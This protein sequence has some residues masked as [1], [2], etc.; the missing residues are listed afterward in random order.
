MTTKRDLIEW[1]ESKSCQE[2]RQNDACEHGPCTV[3][4]HWA[5]FLSAMERFDGTRI[6]GRQVRGWLI[7]DR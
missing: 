3:N 7:Q 2:R 5:K 4:A 1:A 6:D